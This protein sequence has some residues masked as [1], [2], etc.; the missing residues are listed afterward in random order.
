MEV[1]ALLEECSTWSEYERALEKELHGRAIL[2]QISLSE[3]DF[4]ILGKCIGEE[5]IARDDAGCKRFL[6][7]NAPLSVCLFLVWCGIKEYESGN[8]WDGVFRR[9]KLGQ[10]P[11]GF[12]ETV[13]A[14]YALSNIFEKTLAKHNLEDFHFIAKEGF[15]FVTPILA[16]GGIPDYCLEDFFSN[17]L[18]PLLQG[19][20]EVEPEDIEGAISAWMENYR[21]IITDKPVKRFLA[22]GGPVAVDLVRRCVEM[23]TL[24]FEEGKAPDPVEIDLPPSITIRFGQWWENQDRGV[25]TRG[26][27]RFKSPR[28]VLDSLSWEICALLP[29]Q[30]L[31]AAV[32]DELYW[33][34]VVEEKCI[35]SNNLKT[36]RYLDYGELEESEEEILPLS[37]LHGQVQIDL[38]EREEAKQLRRWQIKLSDAQVTAGKY[39]VFKDKEQGD[40]FPLANDFKITTTPVWLVK[41]RSLEVPAE[42]NVLE[43]CEEMGGGW[44]E[45]EALLIEPFMGSDIILNDSSTGRSLRIPVRFSAVEVARL[46]SAGYLDGVTWAGRPVYRRPPTLQLPEIEDPGRFTITLVKDGD[47]KVIETLQLDQA[48]VKHGNHLSLNLDTFYHIR[49]KKVGQFRLVIRG[50]LGEY[51]EFQFAYIPGL[52]LYFHKDSYLPEGKEMNAPIAEALVVYEGACSPQIEETLPVSAT[53]TPGHFNVTVPGECERFHIILPL[54]EGS[55]TAAISVS[56]PRLRFRLEGLD[57]ERTEES[58]KMGWKTSIQ[59]IELED[60]QPGTR[61]RIESPIKSDSMCLYLENLGRRQYRPTPR[62][63]AVFNLTDYYDTIAADEAPVSYLLLD[64]LNQRETLFSIPLLAV[65]KGWEIEELKHKVVKE[66]GIDCLDLSW[67]EKRPRERG[68]VVIAKKSRPWEEPTRMQVLASQN[69]GRIPFPGDK[70]T[71]GEYS[72]YFSLIDEW[73][74]MPRGL[75]FQNLPSGTDMK[76]EIAGM[77]ASQPISDALLACLEESTSL[78]IK[79]RQNPLS[80]RR[81]SSTEFPMTTDTDSES[82]KSAVITYLYWR[83]YLQRKGIQHEKLVEG[84]KEW[85]SLDTNS[86]SL[87]GLFRE[88]AEKGGLIVARELRALR[89]LLHEQ[90]FEPPFNAGELLK[91]KKNARIYRYIDVERVTAGGATR[92]MLKMENLSERIISYLPIDDVPYLFPAGPDDIPPEPRRGRGRG[93]KRK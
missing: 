43:R 71:K 63:S 85:C 88:L 86:E 11:E 14:K 60:I 6:E 33:N 7:I 40:Y 10:G 36:S 67:S 53:D 18:M 64:I 2:G 31:P 4:E 41:H 87:E 66:A 84:L 77:E 78:L 54:G 8:F 51:K 26:G 56:V 68:L 80:P 72:L 15:R 73:C 62:R 34:I 91:H 37:G 82:I 16:H 52:D 39:L 61:I 49:E 70:A 17:F 20:L 76:V 38:M 59:V 81:K 65:Q 93:R 13:K 29:S 21:A 46:S 24:A 45:F 30:T 75:P 42:I 5:I 74:I 79:Y 48:A 22:Y 1:A 44:R 57:L 25:I 9:L 23:A 32:M 19:K 50:K 3:E 90:E 55:Q 47:G 58:S 28:I 92:R 12:K 89:T 83:T 69:E 27:R 35:Y